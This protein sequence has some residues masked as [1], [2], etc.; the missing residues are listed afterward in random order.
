[1]V[2]WMSLRR[3]FRLM[4]DS[5]AHRP[6]K[7][8]RMARK[9]TATRKSK[10][11]ATNDTSRHDAHHSIPTTPDV[12]RYTTRNHRRSQQHYELVITNVWAKHHI[13]RRRAPAKDAQTMA[14]MAA[15]LVTG[16]NRKDRSCLTTQTKGQAMWNPHRRGSNGFLPVQSHWLCQSQQKARKDKERNR[17][18]VCLAVCS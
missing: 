6:K 10:R 8:R 16:R 5:D 2:S 18:A 15:D 7:K 12:E 17:E 9:N 13:A 3:L 1:M 14:A 11:R 4:T